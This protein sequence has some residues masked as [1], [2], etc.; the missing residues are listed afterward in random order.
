MTHSTY[1]Q[2]TTQHFMIG[3]LN[4]L[5]RASDIGMTYA[6]LKDDP[7]LEIRPRNWISHFAQVKSKMIAIDKEVVKIIITRWLVPS[8]PLVHF[9][10]KG[11]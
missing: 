9:I 10:L 7:N 2:K 11:H 8:I 3:A 6:Q 1:D 4:L 5:M